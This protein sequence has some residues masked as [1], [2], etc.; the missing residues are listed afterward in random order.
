[1]QSGHRDTTAFKTQPDASKPQIPC[2]K[3]K[4]ET[5]ATGRD[6]PPPPLSAPSKRPPGS[7]KPQ[8]FGLKLRI[9]DFRA[10]TGRDPPPAR[11]RRANGH[12]GHRLLAL[13]ARPPRP[14]SPPPAR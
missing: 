6:P 14:A 11:R 7:P 12:P 8:A 1:M 3:L 13:C 5:A 2:L 9:E 10:A 4:I